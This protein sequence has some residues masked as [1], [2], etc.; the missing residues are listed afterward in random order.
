MLEGARGWRAGHV[1]VQLRVYAH[2]S[3][4]AQLARLWQLFV[5]QM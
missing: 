4:F 3:V 5:H 1:R 2:F